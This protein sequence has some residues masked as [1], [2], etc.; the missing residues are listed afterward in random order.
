VPLPSEEEAFRSDISLKEFLK[1]E[2]T[3]AINRLHTLY[4]QMGLMR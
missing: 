1:K 2:R 3:A 4:A